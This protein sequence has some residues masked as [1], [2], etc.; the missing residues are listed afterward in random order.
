MS[1]VIVLPSEAL[2][3]FPVHQTNLLTQKYSS[4]GFLGASNSAMC[5]ALTVAHTDSKQFISQQQGALIENSWSWEVNAPKEYLTESEVVTEPCWQTHLFPV[6][7][8]SEV[9]LGSLPKYHPW[10]EVLKLSHWAGIFGLK[11]CHHPHQNSLL[12]QM[13]MTYKIGD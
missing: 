4:V 12:I 5:F 8:V 10:N 9:E 13:V 2:W 7:P 3:P 11:C 1:V 6:P